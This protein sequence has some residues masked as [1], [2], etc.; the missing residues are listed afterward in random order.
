MG[1]LCACFRVHGKEGN[2][3]WTSTSPHAAKKASVPSSMMLH[4]SVQSN[5][6]ISSWMGRNVDSF[7]KKAS[8][9]G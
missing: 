6:E 8:I 9:C 3:I 5:E 4:G 2:F 7:W 1:R